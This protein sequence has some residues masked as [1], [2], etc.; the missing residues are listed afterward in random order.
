MQFILSSGEIMT[1][2]D[3]SLEKT[4]INLPKGYLKFLD[5][6]VEKGIFSSRSEAIRQAVAHF[7]KSYYYKTSRSKP[8]KPKMIA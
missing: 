2:D 8:P 1:L 3:M 5:R 4:C 7:I 6:L